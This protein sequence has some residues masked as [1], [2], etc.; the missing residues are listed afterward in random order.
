MDDDALRFLDD[1]QVAGIGPE[2][3][4]GLGGRVACPGGLVAVGDDQGLGPIFV[5]APVHLKERQ[6]VAEVEVVE[7]HDARD[8][9]R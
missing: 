2:R 8:T 7:D 1:P 9:A 5:P 3:A 4:L 6:D